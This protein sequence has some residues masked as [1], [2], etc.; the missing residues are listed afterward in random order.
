MQ[1]VP[2]RRARSCLVVARRA[3]LLINIGARYRGWRGRRSR[4]RTLRRSARDHGNKKRQ[5]GNVNRQRCGS[6]CISH[7]IF[8]LGNECPGES[9]DIS[10]RARRESWER[11]SGDWRS[12]QDTFAV[13]LNVAR[14]FLFKGVIRRAHQRTRLDMREA[15]LLALFFIFGEF[16]GV[17]VSHDGQMFACGL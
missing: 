10:V 2:R 9:Y 1:G 15:H 3:T 14:G 8:P 7:P 12:Q 5:H 13:D 17:D 4:R 11:Q 16:I 6:P